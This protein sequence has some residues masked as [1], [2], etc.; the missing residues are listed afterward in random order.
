MP[1]LQIEQRRWVSAAERWL[2]QPS[3]ATMQRDLELIH[4]H[5]LEEGAA[6]AALLSRQLSGGDAWPYWS[7]SEDDASFRERDGAV[8]GCM[9]SFLASVPLSSLGVRLS[10]LLPLLPHLIV[11]C[12]TPSTRAFYASLVCQLIRQFPT[13][14][15]SP[16]VLVPLLFDPALSPALTEAFGSLLAL[17]PA[18][19][20]T[21]EAAPSRSSSPQSSSFNVLDALMASPSLSPHAA[22]AAAPSSLHQPSAPSVIDSEDVPLSKR[23]RVDAAPIDAAVPG[24]P[25]GMDVSTQPLTTVPETLGMVD[26]SSLSTSLSAELLLD[27]LASLSSSSPASS[28]HSP[29]PTL[30]AASRQVHVLFRSL[31]C[32]LLSARPLSL[33]V[34]S[35]RSHFAFFETLM[36]VCLPY[37]ERGVTEAQRT[38]TADAESVPQ[39]LLRLMNEW[40]KAAVKLHVASD[41][42]ADLFVFLVHRAMRLTEALLAT[43]SPQLTAGLQV[44]ALLMLPWQ[45][46]LKGST[47]TSSSLPPVLHLRSLCLLSVLPPAQA[48]SAESILHS[49]SSSAS[50]SVRAGSVYAAFLC[51]WKR[52][53][54][55]AT[56]KE[57]FV[58]ELWKALQRSIDDEDGQVQV[59]QAVV[60]LRLVCISA[61]A[62]SALS[63][64]DSAR[65]LRFSS[66]T[67]PSASPAS[68]Y[69]APPPAA[70]ENELDLHDAP[71]PAAESKTARRDSDHD[72]AAPSLSA[73]SLF[74]PQLSASSSQ[75]RCAV[76]DESQPAF[77]SPSTQSSLHAELRP[78]V[79]HFLQ[80]STAST[81]RVVAT[82]AFF[83]LLRHLPE[84]DLLLRPSAARDGSQG[85]ASGGKAAR[86]VI[87]VED[88]HANERVI[89][90]NDLARQLIALLLDADPAVRQCAVSSASLLVD[91]PSSRLP[92]GSDQPPASP[93]ST[94][95]PQW[96]VSKGSGPLHLLFGDAVLKTSPNKRRGA[97]WN[98]ARLTGDLLLALQRFVQ[99]IQ[100]E[101][102]ERL[103]DDL[104]VEVPLLSMA[105][106]LFPLLC[107]DAQSFLLWTAVQQLVH[108]VEEV[109]ECAYS[110]ILLMAQRSH[111]SPEQLVARHKGY[112]EPL[113]L[114]SAEDSPALILNVRA[115]LA[116]K[117]DVAVFINSA[118]GSVLPELIGE[119][120]VLDGRE[121]GPER[122]ERLERLLK[123]LS[124]M[125]RAALSNVIILHLD[126]ILH[127]LL[128]PL[129]SAASAAE[130]QRYKAWAESARRFLSEHMPQQDISAMIELCGPALLV[131]CIW[132][133]GE[134]DVE[135]AKRAERVV[136]LVVHAMTRRSPF[137]SLI[138]RSMDA[139]S[140]EFMAEQLH[141]HFLMI[142]DRLYP[143]L[144][145]GEENSAAI[146][147]ARRRTALRALT[148]VMRL[149]G[150]RFVSFV[151]KLVAMLK[152]AMAS[153]PELR[154][155]ALDV[156]KALVDTLGM[157]TTGLY[158]SQI[159]RSLLPYVREEGREG[160]DGDISASVLSFLR[161]LLIDHRDELSSH[162]QDLP[163]FP[164]LPALLSLSESI[165]SAVGELPLLDRVKQ[166]MSRT[167]LG[168]ESVE[169]RAGALEQLHSLFLDRRAELDAYSLDGSYAELISQLTAH[170]LRL[171]TDT[172]P[173]IQRLCALCIGELGAIDPGH[174]SVEVLISTPRRYVDEMEFRHF[175][176][177]SLLVRAVK[178]STLSTHQDRAMYSVQEILRLVGCDEEVVRIAKGIRAG[179]SGDKVVGRLRK[180]MADKKAAVE[181]WNKLS[182]ATRETIE[183]CITSDYMMNDQLNGQPHAEADLDSKGVAAHPS[184]DEAK[185]RTAG[186]PAGAERGDARRPSVSSSSRVGGKGKED[187]AAAPS[188]ALVN[189]G[190]AHAASNALSRSA[191]IAPIFHR[192]MSVRKW[193]T[194][195]TRCMIDWTVG[196]RHAVFWACR[197]V[198][199]T[200]LNVTRELLPYLV[201]NILKHG[202]D[203]HVDAIKREIMAVLGCIEEVV[204]PSRPSPALSS[205]PSS[206]STA[207]VVAAPPNVQQ[208]TQLI[209]EL[210]DHITS[211]IHEEASSDTAQHHASASSD[212]SAVN[213]AMRADSPHILLQPL[214][215][216]DAL[217]SRSVVERKR[218]LDSI[219]KRTLAN[220][221]YAC[222]AFTRA[223]KYFESHLHEERQKWRRA[224]LTAAIKELKG[225]ASSS[226]APPVYDPM[227]MDGRLARI[228]QLDVGMADGL[229]GEN[230]HL[231]QRLYAS[232]E[233]PDGMAGIAALRSSSSSL[234]EQIRDLLS[235]GQWSDA[236]TCYDQAL[237]TDY[238]NLE[239]HCGY[240]D[241]LLHL[242]RLSES[243]TYVQGIVN[244]EKHQGWAATMSAFGV[245]AAWRMRN[246]DQ[247]HDFLAT[248]PTRAR[249]FQVHVADILA[250]LHVRDDARYTQAMHAGRTAVME[251]LST[252]S[253]ESYQ[254]AYSYCVQ[255]QVLQE[256]EHMR[257][258]MGPVPTSSS[259][260][261]AGQS[262]SV[263][264]S[265]HQHWT[266]RLTRT[267]PSFKVR[268]PLLSVRRVLYE[269]YGESAEVGSTWLEIAHQA[270]KAGQFETATGALLHAEAKT[271]D[272]LRLAVA[273]A[274]LTRAK[275]HKD[276]ALLYLE[277]Q[278]NTYHHTASSFPSFSS[279][280]PHPGLPPSFSSSSSA[281]RSPMASAAFLL[282]GK[283]HQELVSANANAVWTYI[284]QAGLD[285]EKAMFRMGEFHDKLL[286]ARKR[287]KM[288]RLKE[289]L[290]TANGDRKDKDELAA[291]A[292]RARVAPFT[293][294]KQCL[295]CYG[296]ALKAGHS[297]TFQCL[298]RMLTL[299][300]ENAELT[301]EEDAERFKREEKKDRD[302]GKRAD[303]AKDGAALRRATRAVTNAS[304]ASSSA[305]KETIHGKMA[306]LIAG[307]AAF[308]WYTA[309]PQLISR[310][311][312]PNPYAQRFI[313][314]V[315]VAVLTTYPLQSIWS[316]GPVVKSK[317]KARKALA[318]RVLDEVDGRL[319]ERDDRAGGAQVQDAMK[320]FDVLIGVCDTEIK[321][322]E[323][324][325][326]VK[327]HF[328]ALHKIRY[329]HTILVPV[330]SALTVTLPSSALSSASA[331]S[332]SQ[333]RRGLAESAMSH[334]AFSDHPVTV[335][336]VEDAIVILSSKERPRKLAVLGSDGLRYVFLCKKEV[337]GDMRKNSRMMEFSSVVNRLLRKAA[338]S[339][340]RALRLRTFSVLPLTEECGLIE[341]VPHTHNF[342]MLVKEMH[343]RSGIV[344]HSADIKRL[345][346]GV[347]EERRRRKEGRERDATV[348]R[349]RSAG[350][351][352]QQ[353]QQQQ[354]HAHEQH[355]S[356]GRRKDDSASSSELILYRQLLDAFPP[357]FHQWFLHAF[358]DPTMWFQSRLSYA[359]SVATWS[360]VG[361]VVGL[362][363]RHGENILIDA[364][365][366]E[367]VHVD[368]DC[369][370]GKGLTLD[371]PERVPFRLT[372][373]VIDGCGLSG[374]EGVFRTSAEVTMAVMKENAQTLLSV[375]HTFLY[376]P[377]LEWKQPSAQQQPTHAASLVSLLPPPAAVAHAGGGAAGGA[378]AQLHS[379]EYNTA[380][381]KLSE[382][383]LK[384]SGVVNV[385]SKDAFPLSINGQVDTLIKDAC[386]EQNLAQMYMGWMSWI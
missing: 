54:E 145:R 188:T 107:A 281:Q 345:Y 377:L 290:M 232:M 359:H 383:E 57:A 304:T 310:L 296:E 255:L 150:E 303:T 231:L 335:V 280:A 234:S 164:R 109:R 112:L 5:P 371:T 294:L 339:R 274:K 268:E 44:N 177:E 353:Q 77:G 321:Q 328:T 282:L 130:Q 162:F 204:A 285:S 299:Y 218:F 238:G 292:R 72:A 153:E 242:G 319:R 95:A 313:K 25:V 201:E 267:K 68:T 301:V 246:W 91:A 199:R 84:A 167:N 24:G 206:S 182:D 197:A 349:E 159:V 221:A 32:S 79:M 297:Y 75:Q 360:M 125:S 171:C 36:R 256:I 219:N 115:A 180:G 283:W 108:G 176:I 55:D 272:P 81:A 98:Q 183:P 361:F 251:S 241:C 3:C 375:L 12:R 254:R 45:S 120:L 117:L 305:E 80:S 208:S 271:L 320:L 78:L 317:D 307:I 6:I 16:L 178:A 289:Q 260:A 190:A 261:R 90:L 69:Y 293:L 192:A 354:Q 129:S 1:W 15:L 334:Q 186:S 306:E 99:A 336:G 239:L 42:P 368:F 357:S 348:E 291:D 65:R 126:R 378:G 49:A 367:C 41:G 205:A 236:L 11:Y 366:G 259:A 330:Q 46:A 340:V 253:W 63:A 200:D 215:S 217:Q 138:D 141:S 185:R 28:A 104:R 230:L 89:P 189:G 118:L 21:S 370:F 158:L 151:P 244:Q 85:V 181:L 52:W 83:H 374:I 212:S 322:K 279:L 257:R 240:L 175:V 121:A 67:E 128:L 324:S 93:R 364:R 263:L 258:L 103:G 19:A 173:D 105:V 343:E 154:Q 4:C 2:R 124:R 56:A 116:G 275:G 235:V 155:A 30:D 70:D 247:V 344:M 140:M 270:R 195:W 209:F 17:H 287:L 298:P 39:S 198:V 329:H 13:R 362:G 382:V 113:L 131:N 101:G 365:N 373:N 384:L 136:W 355:S 269:E 216:P 29:T 179:K 7:S 43:L 64:D 132:T 22:A 311:S 331:P 211:W 318:K 202:K 250:A 248:L 172:H 342:R 48:S 156:W 278:T 97:G 92:S 148:S 123:R 40:I 376:D 286:E 327:L 193:L 149:I 288:A 210:I 147:L 284:H 87:D 245:Q 213:N 53:Q 315:L 229:S 127:H 166:L 237:Q 191:S 110:T 333:A 62:T 82:S 184:A 326:S 174:L 18:A 332:P 102:W 47:S 134:D 94:G 58:R 338:D 96:D 161:Y 196:P 38:G 169:V 302:D 363:D 337:K 8:V 61:P 35:V 20:S 207:A 264:S 88:D 143:T 66:P 119:Q 9:Q 350:G 262:A 114:K 308:K 10:A 163:M 312:H 122:Q 133:L 59:A 233:E 314:D 50:P 23:R 325:L 76:C 33:P 226:A 224:Q 351:Q 243:L 27:Q 144:T 249:S 266:Q 385:H 372:A 346:Q 220:A 37:L 14:R 352:Q 73:L 358:P 157:H 142:F 347:N 34:T 276:E 106:E 300:L 214:P 277:R 111:L 381:E 165:R 31:L 379:L 309:L 168:H 316:I 160:S 323:H 386:S 139:A 380:A 369:L 74:S 225:R 152:I 223:L 194:T 86:E 60:L 71:T 227:W 356:R 295:T 26:G 203:D 273:R 100:R 222:H 146:P 187:V 170:L 252:A 137:S 51:Q 228:S 265:L 341:W 135:T